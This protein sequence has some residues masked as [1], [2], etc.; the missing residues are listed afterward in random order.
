MNWSN[1][2]DKIPEF[3]QS[4]QLSTEYED[5]TELW[6]DETDWELEELENRNAYNVFDELKKIRKKKIAELFLDILL[7]YI[8]IDFNVPEAYFIFKHRDYQVKFFR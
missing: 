2:R 8:L 5:E 7:C 1:W 4:R 6:A 3:S